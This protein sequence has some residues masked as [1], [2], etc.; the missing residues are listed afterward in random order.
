MDLIFIEL[1]VLSVRFLNEINMKVITNLTSETKVLPG[2]YV[3]ASIHLV[4]VVYVVCVVY[5]A[6]AVD[7]TCSRCR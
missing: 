4:D 6:D 5:V 1:R 3:V 7:A 2:A